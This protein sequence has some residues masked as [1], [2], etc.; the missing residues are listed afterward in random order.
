MRAAKPLD[1]LD[2]SSLVTR[3]RDAA[4]DLASRDTAFNEI[5]LVLQDL[6]VGTAYAYV[7]ESSLAEDI[8]QESFLAAWRQ[9]HKL[10]DTNLFLPWFKRII[11]SRCHRVVPSRRRD[12][13]G[14]TEDVAITDDLEDLVTRRE[15]RALVREALDHLPVKERVAIVLFYFSG[16]S[17]AAIAA[18][19]GVPRTTVVKRLYSARQHLRAALEPFETIIERSRPSRNRAFAM[20]VRAGIYDDYV[21]LYRFVRRPDLTV[22]VERVGNRLISRSAGQKNSAIL[23]TRLSELRTKEFDG[24]AHFVR[25]RS[26]RVTHF[27][28]YEFGRR[29]G[30][31]LKVE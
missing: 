17:H 16:R 19:L 23:G 29:M 14:V 22:R 8:A 5:V 26:G 31:A 6:A 2:L 3:A 9:L 30:T 1:R 15:R 13:V 20:M 27:V 7:R 25:D 18:F 28:Y 11:A 21:G 10:R 12:F 4:Q 24:K